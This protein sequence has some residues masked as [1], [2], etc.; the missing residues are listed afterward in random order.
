MFSLRIRKHD[1]GLRW[2]NICHEMWPFLSSFPISYQTCFILCYQVFL[3]FY[4]FF[5]FLFFFFF[6]CVCVCRFSSLTWNGGKNLRQQNWER[7]TPK[8]GSQKERK[9]KKCM[10]CF[11][12]AVFQP[13][14]SLSSP[15]S[16]AWFPG[17]FGSPTMMYNGRNFSKTVTSSII[18]KKKR[19][20]LC[21]LL[22]H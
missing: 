15:L 13:P 3:S 11:Y 18:E 10:V 8:F 5:L 12:S 22:F 4:S 6:L 9:R 2:R 1:R 21:P 16:F 20:V 19:R 14:R 7:G 17:E